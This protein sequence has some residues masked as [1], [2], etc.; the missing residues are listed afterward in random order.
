MTVRDQDFTLTQGDQ[1]DLLMTATDEDTGEPLDLTGAIISWMLVGRGETLTKTTAVASQI[2]ITDEE[3]GEFTVKLAPADTL[4]LLGAFYHEAEAEFAETGP[5]TIST[6]VCF[7]T[8]G[9][10]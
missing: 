5:F 1:R 8:E 7:V 6:G 2:E 4:T 9:V 3:A 10:N